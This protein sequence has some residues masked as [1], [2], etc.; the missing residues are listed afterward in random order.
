MLK[1]MNDLMYI[2][3]VVYY[4]LE[5]LF[6]VIMIIFGVFGVM[7][8]I[9]WQ[10]VLLMFII[11]LIVIWLV[12]YFNKKMIK[13]FI[14]LNK[15]IGDFSVCVENNIGGIWFVQVFGNELFEKEC[16]VV[17]NQCFCVIKFFLYKIMVKNGLISYMLI[18]FVMLF[19][20]LCG[21]W[22]VICGFLLY[23]EFVVFVFLMNVLFRFIDKINVII[24][25]YLRGIVGFKSYMELMEIEL[26][27]QDF[28]DVRD[29]FGL[30]GN[31]CYEYVLFGYDDYYNV[32]NDINL[33]I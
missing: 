8:F 10:F 4:G 20:F 26:D 32:F 15:D 30:K 5:D 14:M 2:G 27:I 24:E 11:M 33:F 13:V 6:I 17:N 29:V 23:G 1:L 28:F 22:F 18:W 7:L 12:F 21:M 3:E 9:N 31:I 16:F 19:V 25:M